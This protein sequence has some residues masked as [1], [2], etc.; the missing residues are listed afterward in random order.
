VA[1]EDWVELL[2]LLPLRFLLLLLLPP[3]PA[4]APV[5]ISR[6]LAAMG[7]AIA[8]PAVMFRT[9][10][11]PSFSNMS[12]NEDIIPSSSLPPKLL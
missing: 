3:L 7:P 2:P 4:V 11:A 10:Q 12:T 9:N 6:I 8:S 1:C 5:P